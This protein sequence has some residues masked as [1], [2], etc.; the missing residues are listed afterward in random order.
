LVGCS[1]F[2]QQ[3]PPEGPSRDTLAFLMLFCPPEDESCAPGFESHLVRSP[4]SC[5][6]QI[7][8]DVVLAAGIVVDSECE[9]RAEA[10]LECESGGHSV[11][12][13]VFTA[14][15]ARKQHGDS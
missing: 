6:S 9:S 14:L 5:L 3:T 7:Q 11:S 15:V 1:S 2:Q 4:A 10:Q 8:I 13:A 12:A